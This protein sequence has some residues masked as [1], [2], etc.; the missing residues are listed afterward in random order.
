MKHEKCAIL[1]ERRAAPSWEGWIPSLFNRSGLLQK[2]FQLT[3]NTI[4]FCGHHLDRQPLSED[5]LLSISSFRKTHVSHHTHAL[6][7]GWGLT[8]W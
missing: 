8:V 1:L 5:G 2:R 4:L 6:P 7:A 3:M